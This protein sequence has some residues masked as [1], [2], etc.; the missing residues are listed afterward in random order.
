M[1]LKSSA[2]IAV[3]CVALV[4]AAVSIALGAPSFRGYTGL[5]LIPTA[6]TLNKGEY[7]FGLMT[8]DTSK[9]EANDIFANYGPT[10][11]LEIGFNSFQI[12]GADTRETLIN[13]KYQLMPETE[14]KAGVAFGL[15][16]LTNEVEATAYTVVSKSLARGV[17]V[18][19]SD[20]INIR[21][22]IG[23]GGGALNGLFVGASAFA[24]NRVMFSAEWDSSDVNIGF[25]FTPV[26]GLRLHAAWFDVGSGDNIGL[27]VSY[28]KTY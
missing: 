25:R 3:L 13:A 28:Q 15:I 2:L 19:D 1:G 5:V 26:K 10:D 7:N 11:C 24:G 16:D 21:G 6:E 9:F 17:S 23:F 8:E 18:F 22:H 20:I 14:S 4:A 27:G 12:R